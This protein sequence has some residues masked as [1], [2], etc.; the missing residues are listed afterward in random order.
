[1]TS[2]EVRQDDKESLQAEKPGE[3]IV[4][5]Q[6]TFG[7]SRNTGDQFTMGILASQS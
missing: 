3:C 1:M 7:V 4:Q 2:Q 5:A 6:V